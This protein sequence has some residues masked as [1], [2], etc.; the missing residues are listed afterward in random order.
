MTE[1]W[2]YIFSSPW[3]FLGTLWLLDVF[4]SGVANVVKAWGARKPKESPKPE[5]RYWT[6]PGYYHPSVST[7]VSL[8]LVGYNSAS[9]VVY[10][11]PS[12]HS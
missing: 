5:T 11:P 10:D 9:T 6:G 8:P 4:F 2:K 7:S 12:W 1:F 3:I